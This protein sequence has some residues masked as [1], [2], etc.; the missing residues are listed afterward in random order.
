MTL[1]PHLFS[2]L[3]IGG[4]EV[5]NR[6]L[7]T[8]HDTVMAHDGH[9]TD[10]LIAYQEARA[11][12][13][14]GL[15][16]VQVSGVH[17]T[18]R[19]TSHVLMATSDDAI[20]GYR[21]LADAVHRHGAR[22]CGQLFHP[23]RE[24]METQ[25]GTAPVAYAPSAVPN[26]RFHVMPVPLSLGMIGE[27]VSGYGDAAARLMQA[28]F[29]GCEIVASHGYL[30]A[31]FLNP[32]VNRREDLYGGSLENRL[33]FLREIAAGIRA[34]TSGDFVVGL[35]ITGEEHDSQTIE[36]GDVLTFCKML[37]GDGVIDYFNVVAGTS[38]SLKGAIHIVPPMFFA[39]AYSAPFSAALKQLVDKPVFV[40]GRINQPQTA[41]Q[42]LASGQADMCGMTRAMICD[43]E[44]PAKAAKGLVD[45]IRACIACNQ[46]CIGHFHKGYPISCIQHP[47]TG[48]ELTLGI[49]TPTDR[50]KRIIV[51]GGGPA[52]MKAAA[53]L[54]ARG[55]EVT[56][57]E[58]QAQLGGQARLA[59][60]LPGRAE[61]GGIITN[62][63][64]EME[65]AGVAVKRNAPVTRALVEAQGATVVVI[66][67]GGKPHRPVIE[68]GEGTHVVDVWQV[69]A[70]QANV[71]ANVLIADWRGDWV[72]LGLAEKL[73]RDGCT[74]T[75]CVEGLFAGET[76]HGYVR[77]TMVGNLHRLGVKIEPYARLYGSDGTTIYMEHCA[78]GEPILFEGIDTLVLSQ[79]HD[80]VADL[81]AELEGFAGEV[82]VIGDALT[83]RTAEEAVLEGLKVGRAI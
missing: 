33:R 46:A 51:A 37:D 65:L 47:E 74:V 28:G 3:R 30:P 16:V 73:A 48:R 72:G 62:L 19:Y 4:M 45:D 56:L 75:L 43:P 69:L 7:S 52:G 36:T 8:G 57:H 80:R 29:D 17:E 21:A 44:M 59:Q 40:A 50:P 42:V 82:H 41:E 38:A 68:G 22:I 6:I 83:P 26:S 53:V 63:A 66:A 70:G 81:E 14:A 27:I 34:K 11:K 32:N 18:A 58:A 49:K 54:A 76:I 10:R 35:R 1:F 55:H 23:G 64:R 79:G 12:G 39:H 15:I 78:S 20:P 24:I 77:D 25:D 5:R 13:G 9:V 67:T 2:P 60:L 31:Q 61:F 71:G